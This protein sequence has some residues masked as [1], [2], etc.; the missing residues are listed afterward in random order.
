[1]WI[2]VANVFLMGMTLIQSWIKQNV[3]AKHIHG[4][5]SEQSYLKQTENVFSEYF[6]LHPELV[7]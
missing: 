4:I 6:D 1:M 5:Q 2:Q 3:F 7:F